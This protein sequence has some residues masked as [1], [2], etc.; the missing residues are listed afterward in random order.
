[1]ASDKSLAAEIEAVTEPAAPRVG[2][3]QRLRN[4]RRKV[5]LL[6]RRQMREFEAGRLPFFP[7]SGD[8][9]QAAIMAEFD[10]VYRMGF[11]DA[12]AALAPNTTEGRSDRA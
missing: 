10:R 8:T 12:R 7:C 2:G 6:A 5:D 11:E 4:I 1:M 3:R 9:E